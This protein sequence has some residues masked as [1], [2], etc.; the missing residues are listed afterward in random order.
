MKEHENKKADKIKSGLLV[1]ASHP[2]FQI[3]ELEVKKHRNILNQ[4]SDEKP[5]LIKKVKNINATI[6]RINR[7][8]ASAEEANNFQKFM[9]EYIE[10]GYSEFIIDFSNCEFM[11]STFLGA[12]IIVTKKINL[13]DG[14]LVLVADPKK[15]KVLHALVELS[16]I[17]KV[18]T[19]MDDALKG[20]EN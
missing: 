20:F 17:L 14:S 6:V 12:V 4:E 13:D 18:Y 19:T 3:D 1:R 10:K 11:D 15:L 9:M 7:L 16:K 5:F 2:Q 8:R